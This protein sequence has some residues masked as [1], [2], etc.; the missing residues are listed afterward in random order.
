MMGSA[1]LLKATPTSPVVTDPQRA[2][3]TDGAVTMVKEQVPVAE[4]PLA[5]VT[6]MVNVPPAV[7]VPVIAPVEGFR[8]K[9]LCWPYFKP[10]RLPSSWT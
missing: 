5:S 3:P 6:L 8:V 9:P 4:T 1:G 2:L 7:G 10:P